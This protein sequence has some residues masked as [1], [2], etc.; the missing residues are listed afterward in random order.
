MKKVG[1]FEAKARFSALIDEV[2]AGKE[3]VVTKKGVPVARIS[4][5]LPEEPRRFGIAREL[6]ESGEIVVAENFDAPLSAYLLCKVV[7]S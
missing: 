2:S 6:F 3:I 1:I 5:M 4:P 7:G